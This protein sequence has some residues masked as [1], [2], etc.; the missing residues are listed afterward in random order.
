MKILRVAAIVSLPA[1]ALL[2]CALSV[3]FRFWAPFTD[4]QIR[5]SFIDTWE[6]SAWYTIIV[7][8]ALGINGLAAVCVLLSSQKRLV[9]MLAVATLILATLAAVLGYFNQATLAKRT[10]ELTGQPVGVF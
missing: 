1:I 9:R 3:Y 6:A 5:D 10:T 7:F 8:V 2:A 4:Q